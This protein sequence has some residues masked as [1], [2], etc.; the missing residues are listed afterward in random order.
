MGNIP[1]MLH[2]TYKPGKAG[3]TGSITAEDL[4]LYNANPEFSSTSDYLWNATNFLRKHHPT[5]NKYPH[6]HGFRI[7][8]HQH[9]TQKGILRL[10]KHCSLFLGH[11]LVK[12]S[13]SWDDARELQT[14]HQALSLC[15]HPKL[16]QISYIQSSRS[17]TD[18]HQQELTVP[19]TGKNRG[20]TLCIQ[21]PALSQ[22]PFR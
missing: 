2:R 8:A 20:V 4:W 14:R 16:V 15:P 7:S 5:G 1:D 18:A 17:E 12:D 10:Q 11:F 13:S 9:S 21:V 3:N 6:N 19:L 22:M